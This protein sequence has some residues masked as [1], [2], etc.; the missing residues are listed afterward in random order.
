MSAEKQGVI[1]FLQV[2]SGRPDPSWLLEEDKLEPLTRRATE[3][4][5]AR[6][7]KP[8]PVPTLGYRDSVWGTTRR[9]GATRRSEGL[10][11]LDRG[12]A[13]GWTNRNVVDVADLEDWLLEDARS[14]GF[15]GLLDAAG[16]PPS[17]QSEPSARG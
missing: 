4:G 2:Y 11:G 9:R 16:A 10:E 14:R 12:R 3:A 1:V 5:E 17:G 13:G 8:P 15:G 6:S 7:S